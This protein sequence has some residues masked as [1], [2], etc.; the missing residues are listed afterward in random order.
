MTIYK[1]PPRIRAGQLLHFGSLAAMLI[2]V[3]FGWKSAG[4][5]FPIAFWMAVAIPVAHQIFVWLGWRLELQSNSTSRTIGFRGY[6]FVFFLLFAGRFLSLIAL[7]WLDRGSLGFG[8]F[9]QYLLA[10]VFGVTGLYAAYSVVRYFGFARAA[11]A[12]HFESQYR[13]MPLVTK[14]I[15]RFT[16]NGMYLYA[17]LLLWA[18]GV[19][20]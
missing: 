5:A 3:W 7:A 17:F 15:F 1:A 14:G 6:L 12:D 8:A 18:I 4:R 20:L 16:T 9:P 11:G 2:L 19:C 13:K 10:V